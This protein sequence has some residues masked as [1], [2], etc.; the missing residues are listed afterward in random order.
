[1]LSA[2]F[3][4][5]RGCIADG[6]LL[7]H[8]QHLLSQAA[9]LVCDACSSGER[10]YYFTTHPTDT[11]RRT[12]LR[13]IKACWTC[14]QAH[15]QLKDEVGLDHYEGRSW[16]R[17]HQHALLTMIAFGY[18]QHQRLAS[19]L[20]AGKKSGTQ[21]TGSTAVAILSGGTP[22]PYCRAASRHLRPMPAVQRQ[23]RQIQGE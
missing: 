23:I 1:M 14:E 18:L 12:L 8:R 3:A 13:A 4:A 16:L 22:R 2:R 21:C 15:Q 17:L 20:Q 9:G 10:K 7:S 19:A 5:V 6:T 11:P